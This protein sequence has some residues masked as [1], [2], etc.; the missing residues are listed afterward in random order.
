[1]NRPWA[2]NTT[3]PA[4]TGWRSSITC[5]ELSRVALRLFHEHGFEAATIDAIAAAA[6]ISRRTYFRYFESKNDVAWG[7][8][9]TNST[10]SPGSYASYPSRYR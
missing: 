2:E 9:D 5:V 1:M 3:G 8:F 10:R 6:G 7:E 4:R